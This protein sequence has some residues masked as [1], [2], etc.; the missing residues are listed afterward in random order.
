[1]GAVANAGTMS[2]TDPN[3]PC[4]AVKPRISTSRLLRIQ[5]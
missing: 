5:L 2:G 3:N 1:M 4:Q